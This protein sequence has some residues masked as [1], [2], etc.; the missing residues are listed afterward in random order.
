MFR[1]T[2]KPVDAVYTLPKILWLKENRPELYES[3]YKLLMPMDF[4]V[5]KLTSNAYTDHSMASGTL[6]YDLTNSCWADEILDHYGIDKEKLPVIKQSD[7]C[8][9]TVCAEVAAELGLNKDCFV[10]VGAQD[11]KCAAYGVGTDDQTVCLSLGTSAAVTKRWHAFNKDSDPGVGWS[12][13]VKENEYVTEGVV[14]TAATCFRY[15]GELLYPGV[16]YDVIDS[17]AE[18]IRTRSSLL[19]H[20]YMSGPCSPFFR[21]GSIGNF[22]GI[23]LATRREDYA[24]AVMEG[25]AFQ[26]RT[27]LKAMNADDESGKIVMFGGGAKSDLWSQIVSDVTG[28]P[29]LI[30]QTHEA[31]SAGAARLVAD[32]EKNPLPPL[33]SVKSFTPQNRDYYNE[34]Y[35]QY[36][37]I[38]DRLWG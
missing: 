17:E 34:K 38:E 4:L 21:E 25:V 14:N 29:V 23:S 5:A 11:Q 35:A 19:F 31:A 26:M 1:L 24:L 7:E 12:G 33:S 16:G 15:I 9:G 18:K 30:P 28:L 2:G 10:V 20:P 8:A 36:R 6:L 13:Y 32:C 37:E 3:C 27:L 22:Y